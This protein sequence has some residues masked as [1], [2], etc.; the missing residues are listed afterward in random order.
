[1]PNDPRRPLKST[2][3]VP[4]DPVDINVPVAGVGPRMLV[5]D[6]NHVSRRA[7]VVHY[8][9][10][11]WHVASTSEVREA[12]DLAFEH[13]PHVIVI[14]LFMQQ[15]DPRNIVR[16]LRTTVDQDICVIG[17]A[18]PSASMSELAR[19]AGVEIMMPKPLDMNAV[20]ELLELKVPA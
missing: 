6:D 1:V 13:R 2:Q 4:L 5:I 10:L 12:I 14:E 3:S 18:E 9:A 7:L 8:R 17:I 20:D 16:T 15:A 11:G 19:E